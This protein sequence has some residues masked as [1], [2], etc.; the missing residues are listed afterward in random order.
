MT[1]VDGPDWFAPVLL[2]STIAPS[3]WIDLLNGVVRGAADCDGN[4]AAALT[5]T[6]EVGRF[7]AQPGGGKTSRLWELLAS[8]AS[9]DVG[10]ARV[11]EPHLDALSI[12]AQAPSVDLES[13]DANDDSTWGV[14]AAEGQHPPLAASD[15]KQEWILDG[16]KPWCSLARDVSHALV[17]ATT[18][19]GDRRLFAVNMADPGIQAVD[20]PWVSRGM[21]QIVSTPVQFTGVPAV[22][23]G[24][25]GW[26]LTRPGFAWGGLS[27]AACWLGG[28]IG[29][30]RL[31]YREALRREPDQIAL[32]HL[33]VVDTAVNAA[34]AA[35]LEASK[36]VDSR[37][38]SSVRPEILTLRVRSLV[39]CVAET[40]LLEVGHAL[41][42]APLA[43][44]ETHARRVA[45]LQ[46]Y[47]RQHHA[48][49]DH[50][51]LGRD[52]LRAGQPPW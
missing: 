49:R 26:Y 33:G 8:T 9:V 19:D 50:A 27:V 34:R 13:V 1:G 16:V 23:I 18:S 28:A 47:I 24:A 6:R 14:Y 21:N 46:I 52:L 48:D 3:E 4:V 43:I 25:A 17:T 5:W 15:S 29:V 41:G 38:P 22:P 51:S 37:D 20:A 10:V 2:D 36:I 40:T 32:A 30:G 12:L 45:D 35:L 7:A 31:L 42:P 11:L 44:N 39:A